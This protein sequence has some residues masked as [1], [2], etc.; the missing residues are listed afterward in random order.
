MNLT[1][2]EALEQ[3]YRLTA[4]HDDGLCINGQVYASS[5]ILMAG[6][7]QSDWPAQTVEALT[8]EDIEHLITW[9]PD[10]VLFSAS[11]SGVLLPADCQMT[12]FNHGI[13][14]E[15]MPLASACRTY[16]A[17]SSEGRCVMGVFCLV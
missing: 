8:Q 3:T 16:V 7:F 11:Q 9:R 4:L 12:L 2:D 17:L 13:G 14:F 10:I 5:C 6:R 15:V 1:A